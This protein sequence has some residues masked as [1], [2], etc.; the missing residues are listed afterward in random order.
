[1]IPLK[2]NHQFAISNVMMYFIYETIGKIMYYIWYAYLCQQ[3]AHSIKLIG[4][5]EQPAHHFKIYRR[6]SLSV[7]ASIVV[8]RH[9]PLTT[10]S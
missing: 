9:K 5:K 10:K 6:P 8:Y 3:S 4:G 2:S 7:K 1:M